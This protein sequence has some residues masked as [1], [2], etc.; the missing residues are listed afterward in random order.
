MHRVDRWL[1]RALS[2]SLLL[3]TVSALTATEHDGV[4]RSHEAEHAEPRR[5]I[6][7]CD[8]KLDRYRAALEAGTDPAFVAR[9]TAAVNAERAAAEARLR[10]SVEP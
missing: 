9:W 5:T 7:D 2:P 8:A 6:A 10:T 3:D 4:E 1:A